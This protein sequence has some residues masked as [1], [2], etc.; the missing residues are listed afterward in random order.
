M[1]RGVRALPGNGNSTGR[2]LVFE[3]SV[4]EGKKEEWGA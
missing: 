2:S 1:I 4:V 3:T